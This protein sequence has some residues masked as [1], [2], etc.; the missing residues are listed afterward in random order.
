MNLN[1]LI[2]LYHAELI[3]EFKD[4]VD[5]ATRIKELE[6]KNAE[7]ETWKNKAKEKM[8][9]MQ[10]RIHELEG[11]LSHS[12]QIMDA[13]TKTSQNNFELEKKLEIAM[14]LLNE[15]APIMEKNYLRN[16]WFERVNELINRSFK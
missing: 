13:M 14:E 5:M 8:P 16:K 9:A 6:A 11:K 15:A 12:T 3:L 7:L 4:R 10:M 1:K 2:N